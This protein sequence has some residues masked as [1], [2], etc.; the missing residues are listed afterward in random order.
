MN[1]EQKLAKMR[2]NSNSRV[3]RRFGEEAGVNVD[4]TGVVESSPFGAAG[5]AQMSRATLGFVGGGVGAT[6]ISRSGAWHQFHCVEN[7]G[8]KV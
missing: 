1:Q 5:V 8:R 6:L 2:L 4:P 3:Y 7:H